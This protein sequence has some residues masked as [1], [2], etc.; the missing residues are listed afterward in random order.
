MSRH[1]YYLVLIISADFPVIVDFMKEAAFYQNEEYAYI[2]IDLENKLGS[3]PWFLDSPE[4]NQDL[5][6]RYCKQQRISYCIPV[7]QYSAN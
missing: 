1:K 2:I 7:D 4:E 6:V 5:A 3:K